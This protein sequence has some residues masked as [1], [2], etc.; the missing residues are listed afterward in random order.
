MVQW[1][2]LQAFTVKVHGS[3]PGQG[4]KIP[5]PV[6]GRKKIKLGSHYMGFASGCLCLFS[7]ELLFL[8]ELQLKYLGL[9]LNSTHC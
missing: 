1:L 4:T 9:S 2:G 6:H 7:P 3:T 8:K 5:Q